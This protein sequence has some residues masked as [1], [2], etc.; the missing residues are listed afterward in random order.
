[1]TGVADPARKYPYLAVYMSDD[2]VKMYFDQYRAAAEE[3]G[4][5]ASPY[6]MGHLLPIY[7]AE[8]DERAR[9]EAA[10]HVL[11]LYHRG[12]RIPLNMLFPPGYVTHQ[13]MRHILSIADELDYANMSFDDFNARGYCV[14]GSVETV[15]QR[16]VESIGK[17]GYGILLSL[18][19]IGDMPHYR[20]IKNMELFATEVMPYLKKE[21]Q[22][23]PEKWDRAA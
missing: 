8:T 2:L 16:L 21:F 13:S 22:D 23:M 6:Q 20:T 4:Y 12:L 14:V 9:E 10:E 18:L 1:M 3:S 11:W 15:K 5:T 17:L 19:Q 7:V